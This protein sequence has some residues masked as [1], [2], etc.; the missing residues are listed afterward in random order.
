MTTFTIEDAMHI[1][2]IVIGWI[3]VSGYV[4]GVLNYFVKR[5]GKKP[6]GELP[7][8]LSERKG[9]SGFSRAVMKSHIYV[10]MFLIMVI[11][12]HLLVELIHNGF[13][14]TGVI[15]ISLMTLQIALGLY[16]NYVK[17]R[18]KGPWFYAH[19]TVAAALAVAISVHVATA[20]ILQP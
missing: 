6:A 16:G 5:V 19:R 11:L 14:L 20:I 13:F 17:N 7:R 8:D 2:G 15:T 4:W 18:K 1:T 9:Y 10:P 12:L 3:I